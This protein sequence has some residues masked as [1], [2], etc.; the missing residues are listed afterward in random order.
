M[1]N[2]NPATA[3]TPRW[4]AWCAMVA[5]LVYGLFLATQFAPVAGGSDSSGY[6]NAAK[7]LASGN[8]DSPQRDL[9]GLIVSSGLQLQ[10][11]GFTAEPARS[12]IVPTYPLGLPAHLAVVSS[13]FGW[14]LGP[15]LVGVVSTL[16]AIILCYLIARE[17]GLSWPLAATGAALFGAF[18]VTLFIA[19]QPLSDVLATTWIL[20]AVFAALRARHSVGWAF[21]TG[22][23]LS[24]AVFVRPTNVLLLPTLVA[25]I[26][27]WRSLFAAAAG[28]LPGAL[29]LAWINTQLYGSPWRM[30]YGSIF[31]SFGSVY[32]WPTLLHFARWLALLLPVVIL[33]LPI[34]ALR[35]V[36]GHTNLLI[37]LALWFFGPV[38]F[39]AYYEVSHEVWWCLRFILPATPALIL[40]ALLGLETLLASRPRILVIACATLTL[41]SFA[42]SFYWTRHFHILLT[43]TYEQAYA[44]IGHW[45][46]DHLTADAVLFCY[47]ES[48][49]IH[50]YTSLPILRWD[51]IG[52]EEFARHATFLTQAKRPLY[53]LLFPEDETA[54]FRDRLLGRWEKTHS[55]AGR[56]FWHYLGPATP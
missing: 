25:L 16:A 36:Q 33:I 6:L 20:V 41:W 24:I 54:V 12:R 9:S 7:L 15:L 28:G 10:P 50:Y 19:I 39:Y 4:F 26:P 44:D 48:G 18:P 38:F 34:A 37:A 53:L 1:S 29:G 31:D 14:T 30:G 35:R 8:L 23:A 46:H 13:L 52:P 51:Q 47:A 40:A 22:A 43:K 49:A 32:F 55:I 42:S 3:A 21:V 2:P 56:N 11:F 27:S 5:L 45:A 17:I